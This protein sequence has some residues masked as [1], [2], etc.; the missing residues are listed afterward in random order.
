MARST[1]M[2]R[3]ASSKMISEVHGLQVGRLHYE[4]ADFCGSSENGLEHAKRPIRIG[5]TICFHFEEWVY[6]LC[7]SAHVNFVTMSTSMW[8]AVAAP[9]VGP[10]LVTTLITPSGIPACTAQLETG[11]TSHT[12]VSDRRKR[13]C[14]LC[15]MPYAY[16]LG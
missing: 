6:L 8:D 7:C 1:A 11:G 10:K 4:A 9:A 5:W 13:I 15:A 12:V 14:Y 16:L 2:S 3:S